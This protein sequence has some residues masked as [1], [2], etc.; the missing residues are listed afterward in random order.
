MGHEFRTPLK[1]AYDWY[2]SDFVDG[3][4]R[5]QQNHYKQYFKHY[6]NDEIK[7]PSDPRTPYIAAVQRYV[8]DVIKDIL[9]RE[10]VNREGLHFLDRAF[11]HPQTHEA[12]VHLLINALNDP[13]FLDH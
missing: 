5:D 11:R 13:R 1:C 10:D 2:Y 4:Y 9:L 8:G 6:A 3:N 7:R 12:G